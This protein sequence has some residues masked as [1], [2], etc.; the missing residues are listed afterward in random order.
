[1][2]LVEL[3]LNPDRKQLRTFG[4]IGLVVFGGLGG[5]AWHNGTLMGFSLGAFQQPVAVVLGGLAGFCGLCSVVFPAGNKPLF[6]GLSVI[7]LPIGFVISHLILFTMFFVVM[8]PI[9]LLLRLSGRDPLARSLE[10]AQ[11][12]YWGA[13][14]PQPPVDRYF[15]QF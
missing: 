3:N 14:A 12:S 6:V 7:T 11:N 9:G 15:R 4:L 5:W 10:P 13:R 1:M 8:T 2:A